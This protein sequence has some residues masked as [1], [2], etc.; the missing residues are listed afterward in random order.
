[1][2]IPIPLIAAFI[3][4]T[5]VVFGGLFSVIAWFAK[6]QLSAFEKTVE[7]LHQTIAH[8]SATVGDLSDKIKE[9]SF[10]TSAQ[11]KELKE[12]RSRLGETVL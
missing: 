11:S 10:V 4:V 12:L 2:T 5:V 3:S 6:A 9:L 8:L 1:M 7:G